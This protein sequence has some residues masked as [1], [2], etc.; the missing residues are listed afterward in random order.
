MSVSDFNNRSIPGICQ[1]FH[2]HPVL[3]DAKTLVIA[4]FGTIQGQITEEER[5]SGG[6]SDDMIRVRRKLWVGQIHV[7]APL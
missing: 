1:W 7:H 4:P 5:A 2:P 3:G 6:V